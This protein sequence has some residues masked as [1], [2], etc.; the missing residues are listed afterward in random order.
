MTVYLVRHAQAGTQASWAGGDDVQRPLTREGRHQSAD[1]VET[2]AEPGFA[3]SSVRSSPYRR[4]IETV[5]PLAAALGL[6]VQIEPALAE[7]PS[8]EALKLVRS[9]WGSGAVLCSHG[10]VIPGVLQTLQQ[11]DGI[12]LGTDPRCQKGSIWILEPSSTAGQFSKARY[13]AAPRGR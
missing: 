11:K 6:V 4:C 1:I 2:L 9:L 13:I 8:E 5:A 10:D 3:V 7:G 12:D